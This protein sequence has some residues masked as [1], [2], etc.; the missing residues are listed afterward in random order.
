MNSPWLVVF[1][2]D[3]SLIN[4]NSDTFIFEC[5]DMSG[6]LLREVKAFMQ[7][8]GASWTTCMDT[9]VGKLMSGSYGVT[10]AQLIQCLHSIPYFTE[11]FAALKLVK[12]QHAYTYFLVTHRYSDHT[13]SLFRHLS[14]INM[15]V[16]Y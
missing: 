3:W 12:V 6:E 1:D 2:F 5:L 7:Q 10:K 14:M 16:L 13:I 9:Y 8:P 15:L 11:M 4:E